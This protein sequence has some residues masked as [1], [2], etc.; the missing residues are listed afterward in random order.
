MVVCIGDDCVFCVCFGMCCW[1]DLKIVE[2]CCVLIDLDCE[3]VLFLIDDRMLSV[4]DVIGIEMCD[5]FVV[6][7]F[8]SYCVLLIWSEFVS[9]FIVLVWEV[10][11]GFV[12]GCL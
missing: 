7:K 9:V 4:N 2:I 11:N 3:V 6:E 10:R 1:E 8:K 5:C 12:Y